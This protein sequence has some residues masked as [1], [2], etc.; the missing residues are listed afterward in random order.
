M[1]HAKFTFS[2]QCCYQRIERSGFNASADKEFK[3]SECTAVSSP[4]TLHPDDEFILVN[5][6]G[7]RK[8]VGFKP[9]STIYRN[10][11]AIIN[12]KPIVERKLK[13]SSKDAISVFLFGID[14][15]SRLNLIRAMP[16]TYDYLQA[17]GWFEMRGFNKI[18]DNTFPNLMAMLTGLNKTSINSTCDWKKVGEL[19]KC[20][21][22]WNAFSEAGYVT[23]YAEDESTISTFNY[24]E[25]GFVNPPTDYYL[26][27]FSLAAEKNVDVKKSHGTT[28]CLGYQSYAD[29]VYGYGLDFAVRYAKNP[30]FGLFWTNSFSHEDLSMTSAM[31]ERIQFHLNELKLNGVLDSSI[32]FFFSD[33]GMRFGPIRLHFTGWLE[34][35]LP[36]FYV[37]IPEKVRKAHPEIV[38]NLKTNRDRLSSFYDFHMTLRDILEMSGGKDAS[39]KLANVNCPACQS[40]FKELPAN[41]SCEDAGIS[42][43]WCTCSDFRETDVASSPVKKAVNHILEMVNEELSEHLK[44]AKLKL[45]SIRTARQSVGEKVD[46]YLVTFDVTPSQALLEGTV[47][48]THD[49]CEDME[50]VGSVSRLNKYGNQSRCVK[51]A[52][53]RKYCFCT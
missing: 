6:K 2:L 38:E 5:C 24:Y 49:S 36:F 7:N 26:R 28:V 15:I 51:D 53:L 29:H 23:A 50:V 13:T 52:K 44:C 20:N 12:P 47:R 17:E 35:R 41:R 42:K 34:E 14:S 33:H 25:T 3:I 1:A 11:H 45:K 27:P 37:W 18:E 31:D 43:H 8:L 22:M 32:V 19:E 10:A 4:H 48:C 21:F 40:L 46:E 39:D 30:F 9:S 16:R